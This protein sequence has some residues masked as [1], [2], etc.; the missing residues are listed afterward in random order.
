MVQSCVI[1]S[2]KKKPNFDVN[3]LILDVVRVQRRT[4]L[5]AYMQSNQRTDPLLSWL[6]RALLWCGLLGSF[7]F[8]S[9]DTI[10]AAETISL[11]IFF[12]PK[13]N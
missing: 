6:M 8:I 13:R 10:M 9:R 11:L 2:V 1:R 4:A 5:S 7:I 12:P 3:T